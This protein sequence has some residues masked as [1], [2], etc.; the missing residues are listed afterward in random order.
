LSKGSA[1][2]VCAALLL[3]CISSLANATSWS[4]SVD[5][6]SGLPFLSRGG[7][8]ALSGSYAFWGKDWAFADQQTQFRVEGPFAYA[9]TGKNPA[10]DFDLVGRIGRTAERQLSW[11]FDIDAHSARAG[12]VGG[13][14]AFKFDLA[15]FSAAL[16][17]PQLLAGN[18]GW[19]WGRAEGARIEMRFD[20][21]VAALYFAGGNKSEVRAFFYKDNIPPGRKHYLAT[22]TVSGDV[23]LSPTS[24]ERFGLADFR[25]WP[26]GILDPNSS[27]VDLSFLNDSERP[28]GRHGFVKARADKLVFADGTPARF[29][30]A[31]LTAYALFGTSTDNVKKQAHRLSQLGFNLVRLHHH[32]SEWVDPNIFGGQ[33]APDT[34]TLDAAMLDKLDWWITCLKEEG[35]YVWL[36]LED[37][38]RF[39][40][41]DGIEGFS[42]MKQGKSSATLK[43]YSYVNKSIQ[44]AMKQF[45]EAYLNHQNRYT[46]LRYKEDPVIAALLVTNENDL[47]NH[48]GNALLPDKGVPRH[49]AIYMRLSE[50]FADKHSLS[51]D[52]VW[53]AWEAGPSKLFLNDLEHRFDGDM[54]SQL[55]ALGVMTPIVPTSMWG[56]NPLSSLPALT[57]GDII[58]VHSYGGVGELERNPLYGANL[59]NWLAAAQVVDKPLSATEWGLD[60]Q[61]DLATDR[62]D[63]P[64]Y[65]AAAAAMQGWDALM[66]FAYSQEAFSKDAGTPSVYHA[67]NDP[68]M[69]ASLPAAALLYRQGHVRE[70]STTYVFAPN[71]QALFYRSESPGTS[72]A[73]RTASERGRLLIAMPRVPALPWLANSAIP[74]GAK[75]IHDTEQAQIPA[76]ST[77]VV[78][79]SGELRRNWADGVFAIDT[80]RTQAVMGWIGGKAIS[81]TDVAADV[82]TR[83]ALIA[84]QS[85]DGN[86]LRQSTHIMISVAARSTPESDKL[87]PFYSEPV[88]G[89]ILITAP[90]GMSLS[91]REGRSGK[92]RRLA[93]SYSEGRYTVALNRSLQS[94]WLLL[95]ARRP[96]SGAE[97]T[98]SL[99]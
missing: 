40:P 51:A 53:R 93:V 60:A 11:D 14:L 63:I 52:K 86:P 47:T 18:R 35:I 54:M 78:S 20:P 44:T 50:E 68:A 87:L 5:E 74:A 67:Y 13:G 37:G 30:G 75:I 46:G 10:L 89:R 97:H 77:Q 72:V 25:T 49:D 59:V 24:S 2:L 76:A 26:A 43:G 81:L 6:R 64:L 38:R 36:D 69:M 90:A 82:T 41:L 56:M 22:M 85:L 48:F 71:E 70:A 19:S 1:R 95:Q 45:N 42:E 88:E 7:T 23:A 17:E 33:Q 79:D 21:P 12:V 98:R 34:R 29:W 58:D 31:N 28:A 32:D 16:G 39:K 73:L 57:V 80:P 91:A 9:I 96:R 83:N 62:Q 55:R 99:R 94:S 65:V 4:A 61:G 27:P 84:V 8:E 3:W 92:L 66:F 15:Q